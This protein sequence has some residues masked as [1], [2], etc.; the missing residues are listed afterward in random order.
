MDNYLCATISGFAK[1]SWLGLMLLCL[2]GILAEAQS[3]V[4]NGQAPNGEVS[5]YVWKDKPATLVFVP[6]STF[7]EPLQCTITAI[8]FPVEV[9]LSQSGNQGAGSSTLTVPLTVNT[10]ALVALTVKD[11]PQGDQFTGTLLV[12]SAKNSAMSWK[13]NLKPP[14]AILATEPA[15]VTRDIMQP[16][17]GSASELINVTVHEKNRRVGLEGISARP[18][19]VMKAP[20]SGF[21]LGKN[22]DFFFNCTPDPVKCKPDSSFTKWSQSDGST[23]N[24]SPN[25]GLATVG[26]QVKDL[27]A[28][29]YN[30]EIQFQAANASNDDAKV[31][32]NLRVRHHWAWALLVLLIA[33]IFSFVA[34]KVISSLRQRF[35]FAR[36]I[37]ELRPAWL[38]DEPKVLP[39]VWVSAILKQS[40]DLSRTYWLTGEDEIEARVNQVAGVVGTLERIRIL[41]NQ[42]KASTFLTDLMRLRALAKL[43]GIVSSMGTGLLDSTATKQLETALD[44]LNQWLDVAIW[45]KFYWS[46]LKAAIGQLLGIVIPSMVGDPEPQAIIQSLYDNLSDDCKRDIQDSAAMMAI[47]GRYAKL[48]ILWERKETPEMKDLVAAH[49]AKQDLHKIF[50]IADQRAWARLKANQAKIK[51]DVPEEDDLDRLQAYVPAQF[52]IDPGD[53]SLE[54]TFLFQRGLKFEWT[55][56]AT[57][58]GKIVR[59]WFRSLFR[60]K[61]TTMRLKPMTEE[62]K[63]IQYFPEKGSVRVS[64]N[65]KYGDETI[66]IPVPA[67]DASAPPPVQIAKSPEFKIFGALEVV[68]AWSLAASAVAAILAGFTTLYL[69]NSGFGSLSDYL[70]LFMLGAGIDQS[71]NFIQNLARPK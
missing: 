42:I 61:K 16:F 27:A 28:G 65:I 41:R 58:R 15:S 20:E 10:A 23:R 52:S 62:P 50:Q 12:T 67:A 18:G 19:T 38:S 69:K 30:A 4:L 2:S 43:N 34:T 40:E 53:E 54:H 37:S 33:V 5:V 6:S 9:S 13:V 31:L 51:I 68:E 36:R 29:E 22:V 3:L 44:S 49:Q 59:R 39:V 1:R 56:V 21:D 63:V 57:L 47:E 8:N 17:F 26:I 66:E 24:V 60:R 7:A 71:K 64:V 70:S 11:M 55:F 45:T 32:L 14:T 35:L 46:D 25:G 48:K